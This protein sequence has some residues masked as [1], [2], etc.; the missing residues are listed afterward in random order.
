MD[1]AP[2]DRKQVVRRFYHDMWNKADKSHIPEIFHPDFTFRG[3][4]GPVLVGHDEF[5]GYV[6]D[7]VRAVTG[8]TCDIVEMTEEDDRVVARMRFS[9]THSGDMFGAPASGKSVDWAGSAHF[10]FRDG[11][12]ADLWVLGDVHGLLQQISQSPGD[13]PDFCA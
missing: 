11:K 1:A 7:V 13:Q 9:G 3:S 8:F 2:S 5:A 10:T 12:V 4:L 6:D